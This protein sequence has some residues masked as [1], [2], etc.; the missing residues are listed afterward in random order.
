MR[1]RF[2][3][4]VPD[5]VSPEQVRSVLQARGWTVEQFADAVHA[6]PLEVSAWEAGAVRVPPE[7]AER[8]RWFVEMDEWN[9]KVARV[10]GER[11]DWVREHVP[12]LYEIMFIDVKGITWYSRSEEIREHVAVCATCQSMWEQARR[13]GGRPPEPADAP[14]TWRTRYRRWT[15]RFPRWLRAPLNVLGELPELAIIALFVA[16]VPD[17]HSGLPARVHGLVMGGDGRLDYAAAGRGGE[18]PAAACGRGAGGGRRERRGPR[19]VVALRR[20]G[21][22]G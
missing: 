19:P 5:T 11:C 10:W 18:P 12:H 1:F 14:D 2:P 13:T 16:T 21:G 6:S 3:G 15:K 9:A 20:D 7:Q 22:S 4:L 8:I 17:A